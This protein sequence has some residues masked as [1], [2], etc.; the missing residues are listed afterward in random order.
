MKN[1]SILND[2]LVLFAI[3]LSVIVCTWIAC[4]AF[5]PERKRPVGETKEMYDH[6]QFN[7]VYSECIKLARSNCD[8]DAK[9]SAYIIMQWNGSEWTKVFK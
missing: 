9:K 3:G 5:A 7:T 4:S 1:D 8:Y 2:P 6:T